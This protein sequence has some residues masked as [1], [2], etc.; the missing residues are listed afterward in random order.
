M[1]AAATENVPT[2]TH[3][4]WVAMEVAATSAVPREAPRLVKV[5]WRPPTS[6]LRSSGW[7]E[8]V[9]APNWEARAPMPRP[10]RAIGM[11]T[12]P[13]LA[14]G[15]SPPTSTSVP[16]SMASRPSRTTRRGDARG[17]SLGMA[18]AETSNATDRGSSRNPVWRAVS[19]RTTDKKSGM[20][21]KIP[22]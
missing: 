16:A 5:F 22:D 13:A 19:S 18:S 9:T 12:M 20:V 1:M 7:A 6:A 21:K 3:D 8:T 10:T 15:S 14:P 2:S 11:S 4:A 17:A